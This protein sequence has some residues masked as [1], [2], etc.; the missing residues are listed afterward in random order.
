MTVD[1]LRECLSHFGDDREIYVRYIKGDRDG[2]ATTEDYWVYNADR[3]KSDEYGNLII[4]IT[5]DI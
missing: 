4:D 5:D 3:L 2:S 1:E